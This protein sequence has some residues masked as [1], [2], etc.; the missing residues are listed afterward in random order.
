MQ[1]PP[2]SAVMPSTPLKTAACMTLVPTAMSSVVGFSS[3]LI[4]V[5]RGMVLVVLAQAYGEPALRNLGGLVEH[6]P[7]GVSAGGPLVYKDRRGPSQ[8][9]G[10]S[11]KGCAY[12][13]QTPMSRQHG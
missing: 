9:G 3:W 11:E 6:F 5:T 1:E 7:S 2:H 4:Y 10:G 13:M 12:S 8:G